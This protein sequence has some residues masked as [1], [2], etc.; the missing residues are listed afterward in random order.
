MLS[1][2]M[3]TAMKMLTNCLLRECR[4]D[5]KMAAVWL[6]QVQ[7]QIHPQQQPQLFPQTSLAQ[8]QPAVMQQCYDEET[9]SV[10]Q[11]RMT[12]TCRMAFYSSNCQI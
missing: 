1:Q 9:I 8:K 3:C 10:V 11:M 12:V 2:Q 6:C 5:S 7:F 4:A